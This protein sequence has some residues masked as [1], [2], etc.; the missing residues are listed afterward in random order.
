MRAFPG[1]FL[2][3]GIGAIVGFSLTASSLSGSQGASALKIGPWVTSPKA[4]TPEADPYSRAA[5][6]RLGTV[7]LA[8]ADGI[9]LAAETDQSGDRLLGRCSYRFSGAMPPA[10]FWTLSLVGPDDR[11]AVPRGERQ[12]V[13]SYEIVRTAGQPTEV[14]V[15]AIARPGNW[16]PT[17]GVEH[18][19]LILRLYDSPIATTISPGV[20]M[21]TL[22]RLSCP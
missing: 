11:P 14:V 4:G 22:T 15:A 6:A 1:L 9:A 2:A 16:L 20:Q 21:P 19:R 17:G 18:F 12:A 10:R 13:T 7:P 5:A 3:L 8:I